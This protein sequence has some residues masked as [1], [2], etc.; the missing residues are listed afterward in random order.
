[1]FQ[2]L[3]GFWPLII[4]RSKSKLE[5]FVCFDHKANKLH[6]RGLLAPSAFLVIYDEKGFLPRGIEIFSVLVDGNWLIQI[7]VYV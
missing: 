2:I 6:G 4:P 3:E 1:M 5:S 7:Q